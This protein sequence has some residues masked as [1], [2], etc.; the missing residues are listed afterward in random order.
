[1]EFIR[2]DSIQGN[3]IFV[4]FELTV[5]E[6]NRMVRERNERAKVERQNEIDRERERQWYRESEEENG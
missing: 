4:V 1:M 2:I 5:D 3:R 6:Y